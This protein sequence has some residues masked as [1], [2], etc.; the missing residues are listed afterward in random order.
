MCHQKHAVQCHESQPE[1]LVGFSYPF[2][3]YI[4]IDA[5]TETIFCYALWSVFADHPLPPLS[6]GNFI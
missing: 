2:L 1:R 3:Q 4:P 5:G 6:H